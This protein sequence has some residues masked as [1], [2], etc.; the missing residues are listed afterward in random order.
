MTREEYDE[1]M[2][3]IIN[4]SIKEVQNISTYDRDKIQ[5]ELL[6]VF[7]E[8]NILPENIRAERPPEP[9]YSDTSN[10]VDGTSVRNLLTGSIG[11]LVDVDQIEGKTYIDFPGGRTRGS[12]DLKELL[13]RHD[14]L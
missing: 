6:R 11:K 9:K 1:A 8:K 7:K 14:L 12:I 4:K 3:K 10:L 5:S 13:K 2:K